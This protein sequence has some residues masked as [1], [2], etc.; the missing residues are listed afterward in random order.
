MIIVLLTILGL[1]FYC[2][3]YFLNINYFL[4]SEKKRYC[5]VR[6]DDDGRVLMEVFKQQTLNNITQ[7]SNQTPL[8]IKTAIL[9]NTKKGKTVLQVKLN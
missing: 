1:I 8:E 6:K 4:K 2:L 5:I 9:K 7:T 3:L